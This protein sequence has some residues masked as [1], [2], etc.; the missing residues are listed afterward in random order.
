MH[1][2]PERT[3]ICGRVQA[4]ESPFSFSCIT[5]EKLLVNLSNSKVKEGR[6]EVKFRKQLINSP[7]DLDVLIKLGNN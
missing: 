7:I 6:G 5:A 3:G 2:R 1:Q 4:K